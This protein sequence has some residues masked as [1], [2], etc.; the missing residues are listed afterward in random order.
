MSLLLRDRLIIGLAPERLTALRVSGRVRPKIRDR[1]VQL[2]QT[3]Q[4]SHWDAAIAALEILLEQPNWAACNLTIILSSHFVQYLVLPKGDGLT[5]KEQNDLAQLVF[6]NTFGELSHEWELRTSPSRKQQ[7]LASGVPKKFLEAL[8]DA[9]EG[10]GYL[11]SIQPG[12]MPIFNLLRPQIKNDV[13]TLVLVEPGR[14]SL[15]A[16]KNGQWESIVSRAVQ[17]SGLFQLLEEERFLQGSR[18]G[19]LLWLCDLSGD[20]RIPVD[21]PWQ[22]QPLKPAHANPESIPSLADWGCP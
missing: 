17:G 5:S 6:R 1:Y 4:R 7:S 19:G 14:I 12:L 13:G 22:T 16:I 3:T 15:A 20:V 8:H 21:S 9:C 2:L 18:P 11:R 10:R